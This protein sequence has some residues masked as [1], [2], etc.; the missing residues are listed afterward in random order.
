MATVRCRSV[1][2]RVIFA[3]RKHKKATER[4]VNIPAHVV[5]IPVRPYL[6]SSPAD[7]VEIRAIILDWI[8]SRNAI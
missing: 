1:A 4:A 7:D 5:R 6:G 3:G 2:G 8:V